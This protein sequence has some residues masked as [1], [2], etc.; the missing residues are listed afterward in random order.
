MNSFV[1][2]HKRL[3]MINSTMPIHSSNLRRSPIIISIIAL[4]FF[5]GR[6]SHD[7]FTTDH[8]PTSGLH[9]CTHVTDGDTIKVIFNG[10]T[11]RVRI[12]DIDAPEVRRGSKL[13]E[14]ANKAGVS[15]DTMLE[16]GQEAKS[17]LESM[18]LG[19]E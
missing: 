7:V 6:Y 15:E 1:Q 11:E 5:V 17:V 12:L 9:L 8:A 18:V 10:Q 14:Q 2:L 4:S 19:S 3:D 13:Q 16:R